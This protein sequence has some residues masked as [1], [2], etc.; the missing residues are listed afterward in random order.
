MSSL[1]VPAI[2]ID[3]KHLTLEAIAAVSQEYAPVTVSTE[4]R[5]RVASARR[6][7]DER[8]GNG[9]AIYGVTTGFGRLA[10]VPVAA[11][12]SEQ[13]QVNLVRSHAAGT[14]EPLA[15]RFV[16][17]AGILRVSSLSAGHSG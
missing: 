17:A 12:D 11:A 10:D 13:L 1:E 7:V 16:R 15:E 2:E 4:A 5:R 8:F 6:F 9:D 3:G 14:G